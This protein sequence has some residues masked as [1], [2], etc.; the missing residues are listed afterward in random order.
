[1]GTRIVAGIV[2]L[3]LIAQTGLCFAGGSEVSKSAY[4]SQMVHEE[5]SIRASLLVLPYI[6]LLAPVRVIE[7]IINPQPK[8]LATVPPRSES[9]RH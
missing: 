3:A 5:N 4:W 6:I 9:S 2:C 7:G 8:T 1:M